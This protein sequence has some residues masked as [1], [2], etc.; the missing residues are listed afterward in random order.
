M[1]N[2]QVRECY[3]FVKEK[4][5]VDNDPIC[6]CKNKLSKHPKLSSGSGTCC[7][8]YF[9]L[10]V[11]HLAND[12]MISWLRVFIKDKILSTWLQLNVTD[13]V[14]RVQFPGSFHWVW[15]LL[16]SPLNLTFRN[17]TLF[18]FLSWSPEWACI[19]LF[20]WLNCNVSDIAWTRSVK[21]LGAPLLINL[22]GIFVKFW[23]YF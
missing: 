23:F 13:D 11:R 4:E 9:N 18:F 10:I 14:P 12:V 7:F 8:I 2:I 21:K 6:H 5:D 17:D 22:V 19:K 1:K 16:K 3:K 15:N 20:K